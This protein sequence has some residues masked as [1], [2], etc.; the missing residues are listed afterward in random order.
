M[1]ESMWMYM[2][3]TLGIIGLILINL[4]GQIVV[5]NE[6]NYYLLKE[7]TEAAMQDSVDLRAYREGVGYDG[8]SVSSD[9]ESMHCVAYQPGTVRIIREK[10]VESFMMRFAN[11]ADLNR[12]YRVVV[13]DVDECPPKVSVSLIATNSFDF[14][15]FFDIDFTKGETATNADIVNSITG[16]LE[17]KIAEE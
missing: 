12:N 14:V 9:P 7:I 15:T 3:A 13:H 10:F 6:Q 17:K 16:I 5:S 2:F 1:K 4:F 8:V 11:S